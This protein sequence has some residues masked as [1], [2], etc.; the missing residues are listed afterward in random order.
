MA[1]FFS[2][3]ELVSDLYRLTGE[4]EKHAR[5]LRLREGEKFRKKSASHDML[6]R[7]VV[8]LVLERGAEY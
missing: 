4:N 7:D 6:A 2:E 8:E 1:W 3:E 5:V